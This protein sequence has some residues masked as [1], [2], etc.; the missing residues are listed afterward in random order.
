[1]PCFDFDYQLYFDEKYGVLHRICLLW[2]PYYQ[3]SDCFPESQDSSLGET[4]ADTEVSNVEA[5][6]TVAFC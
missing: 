1:M 6:K 4:T 2:R 3:T 5:P